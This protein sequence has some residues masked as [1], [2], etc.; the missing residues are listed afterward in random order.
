MSTQ[1]KF[2]ELT[3]HLGV[4]CDCPVCG[5][6]WPGCQGLC[7]AHNGPYHGDYNDDCEQCHPCYLKKSPCH[8]HKP[9]CNVSPGLFLVA[10]GR[11]ICGECLHELGLKPVAQARGM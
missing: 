9:N 10:G 3:Q 7:V 6:S 5:Y 2:K 4:D 1:V 8:L 11:E